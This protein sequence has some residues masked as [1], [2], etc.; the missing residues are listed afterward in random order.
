MRSRGWFRNMQTNWRVECG[1]DPE[2]RR[3][4]LYNIK[5]RQSTCMLYPPAP[6]LLHSPSLTSFTETLKP[7]YS[8]EI[9][10]LNAR[11]LPGSVWSV[12]DI[13][14]FYRKWFYYL[15]SLVLSLTRVIAKLLLSLSFLKNTHNSF[16]LY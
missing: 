5:I 13:S 6:S 16:Y 4:S 9:R 12:A 10:A 14:A 11:K 1:R 2:N 15:V 8:A 3:L 7:V